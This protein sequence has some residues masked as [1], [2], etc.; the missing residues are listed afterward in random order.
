MVV[1]GLAA[2]LVSSIS[3]CKVLPGAAEGAAC[4]PTVAGD[5]ALTALVVPADAVVVAV[6]AG[7]ALLGAPSVEPAEP[8]WLALAGGA[9]TPGRVGKKPAGS[10]DE[11]S[12]LSSLEAP[13]SCEIPGTSPSTLTKPTGPSNLESPVKS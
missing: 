6:V 1:A 3:L 4:E 7:A 2:A 5:P 9:L 13:N 11:A 12:A 10:S 8:L